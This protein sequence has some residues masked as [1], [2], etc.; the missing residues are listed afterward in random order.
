VTSEALLG[1]LRLGSPEKL[2]IF[3]RGWYRGGG[4]L[5]VVERL[6]RKGMTC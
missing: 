1:T 6:A 2:E 5:K 3:T 4:G